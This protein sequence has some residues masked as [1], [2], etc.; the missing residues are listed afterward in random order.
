MPCMYVDANTR[1]SRSLSVDIHSAPPH[2][3]RSNNN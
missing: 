2:L 3:H 1:Q